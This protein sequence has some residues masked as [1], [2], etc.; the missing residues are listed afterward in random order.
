[1]TEPAAFPQVAVN[2]PATSCDISAAR[3]AFRDSGDGAHG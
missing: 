1:M 2:R 3:P